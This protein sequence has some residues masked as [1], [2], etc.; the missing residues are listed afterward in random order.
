[1]DYSDFLNIHFFSAIVLPVVAIVIA[2]WT[3]YS[4]SRM[5][6]KQ[7][8]AITDVCRLQIEAMYIQVELRLNE[9]YAEEIEVYTK[10]QTL[11]SQ[12]GSISKEEAQE[13][14]KTIASHRK[15]LELIRKQKMAVFNQQTAL[16]RDQN[17]INKRK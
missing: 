2:I 10:I 9:L 12:L 7:I 16:V 17:I 3:S 15:K 1:M 5:A 14:N 6:T 4:T 13:I 11:T 8:S